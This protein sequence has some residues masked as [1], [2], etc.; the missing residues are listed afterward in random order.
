VV[1]LIEQVLAFLSLYFP[2]SHDIH[3]LR[4]SL[5]TA[6]A[7]SVNSNVPLAQDSGQNNIHHRPVRA[8]AELVV[9]SA[10]NLISLPG[11]KES[12]QAARGI[13]MTLKVRWR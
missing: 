8:A 4:L 5:V 6:M 13:I 2:A 7:T 1:G 9:K 11:I 3:P 12:A 10:T